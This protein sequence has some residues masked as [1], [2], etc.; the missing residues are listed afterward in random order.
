MI[1][2]CDDETEER[3]GGW[4]TGNPGWM[5]DL[6][7]SEL[8]RSRVVDG[9]AKAIETFHVQLS[10]SPPPPSKM[11]GVEVTLRGAQSRKAGKA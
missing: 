1:L 6:Q 9:R 10:P 5:D 7:I 11:E 8:I 3:E 4:L 2:Y